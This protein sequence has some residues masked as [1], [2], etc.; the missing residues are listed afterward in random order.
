MVDTYFY[1]QDG[2]LLH[3]ETTGWVIWGHTDNHVRA[4]SYLW[5]E[6][7]SISA[8][9]DRSQPQQARAQF[10]FQDG[11]G[12]KEWPLNETEVYQ[13]HPNLFGWVPQTEWILIGYGY[14]GVGTTTVSGYH[15]KAL[16]ARSGEMVDS[17]IWTRPEHT[18]WHPSEAGLLVATDFAQAEIGR[19]G[20][21]VTWQILENQVTYRTEL[22]RYARSPVWS[23]D[24]RYLAYSA[25]DLSGNVWLM[26]L[27]TET[28]FAETCAE[29]GTWP[30]WSR[31][32]SRLFY[33]EILPERESV[34]IRTVG[35]E[36]GEPLTVAIG[37]LPRCPGV[38][39]PRTAFDYAP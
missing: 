4:G 14:G 16:N 34:W 8:Y 7:Y 10:D 1:H 6:D 31:D 39:Q 24:G 19:I 23:P 36:Q 22:D 30:A 11:T 25:H 3:N 15:L 29:N 33:L 26:V 28:G 38:C 17:G 18:D 2:Y 35:R 32:S 5:N 27:D 12:R 21:L 37:R 13:G 20:A 9:I